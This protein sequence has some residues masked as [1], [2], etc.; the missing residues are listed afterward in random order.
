MQAAQSKTQRKTNSVTRQAPQ[1]A[2]FIAA[3]RYPDG[4]RD[5]FHVLQAHGLADA[6]AMVLSEVGDVRSLLITRMH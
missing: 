2:D 3:V 6:R 4:R 1:A 5:I